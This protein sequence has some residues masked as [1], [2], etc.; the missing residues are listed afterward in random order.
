MLNLDTQDCSLL[1]GH[2][3][4]VLCAAADSKLE[5]L[6]T[7]S[8]DHIVRIWNLKEKKCVSLCEGHTEAV[9]AVSF[10]H[11]NSSLLVSAS[12]D[13]TLKLWNLNGYFSDTC[14]VLILAAKGGVPATK[15]TVKA[16]DKDINTVAFSPNDKLL[17]SGSQDKSVKVKFFCFFAL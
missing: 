12:S 8:K 16:H 13:Q 2:T 11:Q 3:D 1:V 4:I 10:A 5:K 17:A 14:Q 15:A 6:A 9:S 7:G